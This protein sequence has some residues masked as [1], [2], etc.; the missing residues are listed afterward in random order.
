MEITLTPDSMVNLQ[1]NWDLS[2]RTNA[3]NYKQIIPVDSIIR[4]NNQLYIISTKTEDNVSYKTIG[5]W[6]PMRGYANLYVMTED[7]I[8]PGKPITAYMNGSNDSANP[9]YPVFITKSELHRITALPPISKM[10]T[11][12][13]IKYA[14]YIVRVR[15]ELEDE[16][17]NLSLYYGYFMIRYAVSEIGYNPLYDSNELEALVLR[18]KD[19][20]A[21]KDL[22]N[23]LFRD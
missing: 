12:D 1:L 22:I 17:L 15:K 23:S 13:F 6:A 19:D 21:T 8:E 10:T 7:T 20:P 4:T 18:F 16:A 2:P 3:R 11:A 14:D 9:S 5:R